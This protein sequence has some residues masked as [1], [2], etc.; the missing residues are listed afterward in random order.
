MMNGINSP[1]S[2]STE[3]PSVGSMASPV[4]YISGRD[5]ENFLNFNDNSF[6]TLSGTTGI[7]LNDNFLRAIHF[8]TINMIKS[9]DC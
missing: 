3:S 9:S 4:S 8:I 1:Y 2:S 6:I 7:N 5:D